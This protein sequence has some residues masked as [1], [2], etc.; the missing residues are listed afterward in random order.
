MYMK[1]NNINWNHK[2]YISTEKMKKKNAKI[3]NKTK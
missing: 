3:N 2:K 1:K